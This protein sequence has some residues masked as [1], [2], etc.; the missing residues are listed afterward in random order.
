MF[1]SCF[2]TST[3][4]SSTTVRF[5]CS[6]LEDLRAR[7]KAEIAVARKHRKV[8]RLQRCAV[9]GLRC[10]ASKSSSWEHSPSYATRSRFDCAVAVVALET[11]KD[12]RC[13]G[14]LAAA[15]RNPNQAARLS[16]SLKY[17]VSTPQPFLNPD[18]VQFSQHVDWTRSRARWDC[19]QTSGKRRG[20][21]YNKKN[22][23]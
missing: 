14:V 11:Q 22:G 13:L 16:T 2:L 19:Q 15:V 5:S 20:P 10:I 9:E 12:V 18:F 3:S 4:L 21:C 23:D 1:F 7:G 8:C 6:H 17:I